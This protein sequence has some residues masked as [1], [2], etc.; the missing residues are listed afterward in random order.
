MIK[1]PGEAQTD[2]TEFRL[3]ALGTY[4]ATWHISVNEPAQWSLWIG[5]LPAP[6]QGTGGQFNPHTVAL[7]TPSIVGQATGTAQLVGD[8]VFATPFANAVIQIR[9]FANSAGTATVT[10]A[11]GGTQA[12]AVVLIIQQLA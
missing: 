4:R 1:N 3:T 6:L 7:G 9:N 10:P 5:V 11:P 8:V 12:Q 2:N